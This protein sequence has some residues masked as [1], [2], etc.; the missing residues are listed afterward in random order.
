[1]LH[2][3]GTIHHII[4]IY[5]TMCKIIISPGVFFVFPKF[6]FSGLLGGK[7]GQTMVQNDKL[8]WLWSM[9][10]EPYIVWFLF[11]ILMCK[12]VISGGFFFSFSKFW[13]SHICKMISQEPYMK[14]ISLSRHEQLCLIRLVWR[15][16]SPI[17][18]QRKWLCQAYLK[19]ICGPR[20]KQ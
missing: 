13:F 8:C 15:D 20:Q 16:T 19:N 1:M 6:W 14:Y 4:I 11:M 18:R 10:Q 5:G 7:K 17:I 9:S 3:S 2:I 12:M